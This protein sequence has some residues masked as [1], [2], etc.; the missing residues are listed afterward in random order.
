MN[1]AIFSY[2]NNAYSETFIAAHKNLLD[3]NIFFYYGEVLKKIKLEHSTFDLSAGYGIKKTIL[4]RLFKNYRKKTNPE[5]LLVKSLKANDV[6]VILIEYGT[7]AHALLPVLRAVN[8]PFVVHFHGA[9]ASIRSLVKKCDNYREVFQRAQS[10]IAVS[11]I[12]EKSL[13]N[14]GCPSNKLVYNP[15]GPNDD[16][17]NLNSTK[18]SKDLISI[19]RFVDKK[20][21]YF[22]IIAF[23]EVVKVIP[24]AKL[25][26]AGDG[27]LLD[28]CKNLVDF[29]NIKDSV[30]FLGVITPESFKKL[31]LNSRALVQH[32]IT[33]V[34]G[35]MEGTPVS[36]MEAQAAAVPVISTFHAGIQD[37]VQ[38]NRT[39]ILVEEKDVNGMANAM[40]RLLKDVELAQEYGI[41]SRENVRANFSMSKHIGI[42]NKVLLESVTKDISRD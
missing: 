13:F 36:I 1:I 5:M 3:G 23:N 31:L 17:F 22:N 39:G 15:C 12:M 21:P 41:N 18:K 7:F 19:G 40:I 11:R 33:T 34:N 8:I 28:T 29:F 14:L 32:S 38:S 26:M 9:D 20:A 2:N 35:D 25:Y 37:V 42:L 16:F 4:R 27:V 6:D 10:V 30:I 24:D